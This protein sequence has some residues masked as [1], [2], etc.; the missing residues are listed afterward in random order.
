[1]EGEAG[2]GGADNEAAAVDWR[3]RYERTEEARQK[4]R[5]HLVSALHVVWEG[6]IRQFCMCE[7]NC[8]HLPSH[9]RRSLFVLCSNC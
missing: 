1:M 7:F 9:S 4:L 2:R 8:M 3:F 5:Q 6:S